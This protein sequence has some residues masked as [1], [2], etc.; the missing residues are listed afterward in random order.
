[1]YQNSKKTFLIALLNKLDLI[2]KYKLLGL[3]WI[4][5]NI[6]TS[7]HKLEYTGIDINRVYLDVNKSLENPDNY[8]EGYYLDSVYPSMFLEVKTNLNQGLLSVE[9]MEIFFD[10]NL[11]FEQK[12]YIWS[13]IS[14]CIQ[15]L[16]FGYFV[17][18]LKG[19][20]L[21]PHVFYQD[22]NNCFNQFSKYE[23]F[24]GLYF[25][26][27][28]N[29]MYYLDHWRNLALQTEDYFLALCYGV[30]DVTFFMSKKINTNMKNIYE[31]NSTLKYLNVSSK[32]IQFLI[33]NI[34]SIALHYKDFNKVEALEVYNFILTLIESEKN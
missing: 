22:I 31:E 11:H 10:N 23:M 24:E 13:E 16:L 5:H 34:D 33:L 15:V 30:V 17:S 8:L 26:T 32:T 2:F 29:E 7:I 28:N 9:E 25:E 6:L 3:K 4:D 12:Y 14:D 1:M 20:G 27:Y 18:Q 19:T 21:I